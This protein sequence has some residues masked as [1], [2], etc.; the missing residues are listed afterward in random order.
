M[1]SFNDMISALVT[2]FSI[3]VVNNWFI[4]V[5]MYVAQKG[6]DAIY[7]ILYRSYF[8]IFYY[9]SVLIALNI[10]VAYT[11][12]MYASVERLDE[13]REKTLALVYK[14]MNEVDDRWRW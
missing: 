9:L 3:M 14:D 8:Y 5:D 10:L 11:I 13:E 7:S 2:L 1:Q 6:N 12:D 4:I